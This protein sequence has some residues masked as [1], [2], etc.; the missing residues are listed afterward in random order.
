LAIVQGGV[1]GAPAFTTEPGAHHYRLL[2]LEIVSTYVH[3]QIVE[4]GNFG[5]LQDTLADV[6][7]DITIDRCYIH[8]DAVNGQKRGILLNAAAASVVNS[9]ISDIKSTDDEAQ[10]IGASNGPG[11]FTITNNYIEA[12]GEN[13]LFGGADP[14]IANLVPSD[15]TISGNHI[16]KDP[17]W[18]GNGYSA[19]NLIELKNAQRVVID[20]N[21]LEYCWEEGQQGYAVVLTPRNQDGLSPWSVVQHVQ[22]TNNVFRHIASG[23]NVLGHDDLQV[24]TI[25]TN[26]IVVRNNL[27]VDMSAANWGGA[28]VLFSAQGGDNVVFD[29]NTVFTDGT[30]I[31]FGNVVTTGFVFTNNIVPD[32]A[33]A[34]IGAD[35]APGN[36]S[37]ATYFP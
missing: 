35:T 5:T 2:L 28:G 19:K 7:H 37:I 23:F 12:A 20:A 29:R 14:S 6:P 30:S 8:G 16:A 3:N 26:D 22:V 32:N 25:L 15:I 36:S 4:I 24:N 13:I 31:V 9:Y 1:A 17:S 10:G 34:I 27:F 21:L 33:W 11:P 18:R